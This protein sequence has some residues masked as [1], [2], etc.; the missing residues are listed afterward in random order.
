MATWNLSMSF[1]P[2][3]FISF[4]CK[5][6]FNKLAINKVSLLDQFGVNRVEVQSGKDNFE[7]ANFVLQ[8]PRSNRAA[9]SS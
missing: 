9:N 6:K 1:S 8:E 7:F 5:V 4:L 2:T 3:P